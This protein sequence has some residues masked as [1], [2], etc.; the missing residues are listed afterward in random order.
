MDQEGAA[1]SATITS[2]TIGRATAGDVFGVAVTVG[3]AVAVTIAGAGVGAAA[4]A[5]ALVVEGVP[6]VVTTGDVEALFFSDVMCGDGL[7]VTDRVGCGVI[8][9]RIIGGIFDVIVGGFVGSRPVVGV[10]DKDGDA[11]GLG[12]DV[13]DGSSHPIRMVTCSS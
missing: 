12:V 10:V 8:V 7:A 4:V 9:G 2:G 3:A 5:V 1:L 11:A 13:G 6:G